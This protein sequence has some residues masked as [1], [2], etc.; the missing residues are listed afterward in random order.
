M[1][2]SRCDVC[3][4]AYSNC[5]GGI[6]TNWSGTLRRYMEDWRQWGYGEDVV[7]KYVVKLGMDVEFNRLCGTLGGMCG[8]VLREM[9]PLEEAAGAVWGHASP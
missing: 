5:A 7:A 4:K 1:T 6:C 2:K 9:H 8:G 3:G